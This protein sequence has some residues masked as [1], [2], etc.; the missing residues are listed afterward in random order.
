MDSLASIFKGKYFLDNMSLRLKGDKFQDHNPSIK[1]D[2]KEQDFILYTMDLSYFSGKLEMYLRYKEVSYIRIEPHALEFETILSKNTGCEQLPQ[3]YDRRPDTKDS[4]RWL[5]DTT[6]IIEHL[7][8]DSRLQDCHIIPTCPFQRFFLKLFEDYADEFL[9]RPAMFFRWEPK[10]DREIMGIRFTYEFSRTSQFRY[11]LL[12]FA[13]RRYLLSLRQWLL[14]SYGEGCDT[15]AKKQVIIDQYYEL[16]EI[17]EEILS[18]QFYLFGNHPTLIDFA[19]AGPCFRHFS[20]DFT[21]R[22]IMQQVAPNVYEWLARLWN[23][24]YSKISQQI[25]NPQ[26]PLPNTLPPTWHR[27]LSLLPDYFEYYQL[28]ALAYYQGKK[29][30]LWKYKGETCQ[31]PVVPY[32]AWCRQELLK[33]F[34]EQ[35]S[36]SV[37]EQILSI[38]KQ[39]Q[40]AEFFQTVFN[41]T[42]TIEDSSKTIVSESCREPIIP[43]ECGCMPPFAATTLPSSIV[44]YKWDAHSIF[45]PYLLKWGLIYM[46]VGVTVTGLTTKYG[47]E[48]F[49]A[50][51]RQRKK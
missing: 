44:L 48:F 21:P 26:F 37:Q 15:L 20:S 8:N 31:V 19:F 9:W 45:I 47:Y 40:C 28:N 33:L 18:Q 46:T 27:L 5:R 49:S 41:R 10:F 29:F 34:H 22:K 13:T 7:E 14:S 35:C 23:C 38:L 51:I 32:R 50:Y 30:F 43:P 2:Q 16:L 17:L 3:M 36:E 39:Y 12:P 11:W 1:Q 24:K 4:E 42:T 25:P 6:Y